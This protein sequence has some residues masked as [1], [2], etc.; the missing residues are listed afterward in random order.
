M[1]KKLEF[2][3]DYSSPWTYLAFTKIED[4]A[5]RH[6]A[7]LIWRPF[8]VGGVFNSVNPSVY[9]S[10]TKPVPAKAKYYV[11]DLQDW[12]RYYGV[13]IGNPTVFPVNSVK[14]MRGA[15]VAIEHSLISPYSRR[16]F[17]SYWGED[18][19]ISQ[20]NVIREIVRAV[21]L[22]E[23]EF[24]AKIA[25][26][27]Y[28]AK[29]RANTDELIARGGFGSPTMFVN[30]SMFFGNDRLALVEFELDR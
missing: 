12:A 1:A 18:K 27:E 16:M 9:E 15:F 2:F 29:L 10:R 25:S 28:K 22:D 5:R 26:E 7:E 11:K 21:G 17:E 20:D 14:A 4:V 19:D 8:L 23:K 30:D 3:F 24:F 13:K 6:G